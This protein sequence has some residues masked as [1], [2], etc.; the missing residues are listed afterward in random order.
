MLRA[1]FAGPSATS[2]KNAIGILALLTLGSLLNET[3]Y[4][5]SETNKVLSSA[6]IALV[7]SFSFY[8]V[9]SYVIDK[10][11]NQI[12][13]LR[14]VLLGTLFFITEVLRTSIIGLLEFNNELISTIDWNYRIF[15]GGITGILFFG[16][17]SIVTNDNALN[18][19]KMSEL[20]NVRKKLE[21]NNAVTEGVLADNK[22]RI[23]GII[24]QAVNQ[25]LKAVVSESAKKS[26]N[27]KL[28]VDELVRVSDEVVRPLSHELFNDPF[29]FP[30][31][32]SESKRQR[33]MSKQFLHLLSSTEPFHPGITATLA[34]FQLAPLALFSSAQPLNA[35]Y[36]VIAFSIWIY[37]LY[38]FARKF[39][40]PFLTKL[41]IFLRFFVISAI[42]VVMGSFLILVNAI[43]RELGFPVR[44]EVMFY[45]I[46][47]SVTFGWSLAFYS[48]LKANRLETLRELSEINAKLSWSTARLGAKLW[49]EQKTLASM[50]HR[51]IQGALIASALKY[52]KDVDNGADPNTAIE[53]IREFVQGTS[54]LI[55][56]PAKPQDIHENVQNLNELWDGI[57]KIKLEVD[58]YSYQRICSDLICQQSIN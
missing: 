46:L 56:Q 51:D 15:A 25:A 28:I 42:Y 53:Q 49:S 14:V 34:F 30:Q 22:A 39:V 37:A 31:S 18:S 4:K 44:G 19:E 54:E 26:E 43:S 13:T 7:L 1:S 9:F 6:L 50:V 24:R 33:V 52:K 41:N 10:Y 20:L 47:L 35:I 5:L 58:K 45:I 40:K 2:P 23:I 16:L 32:L 3:N 12:S 55:N 8:Q 21:Q 36:A 38:Y 48:A 57:F 29:E 11:Q 27:A 17:I